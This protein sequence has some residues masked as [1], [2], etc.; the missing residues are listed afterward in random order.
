MN[1]NVVLTITLSGTYY[2]APHFLL[3]KTDVRRVAQVTGKL[4]LTP[5]VGLGLLAYSCSAFS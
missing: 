5:G 2:Y 3:L 1:I 4:S